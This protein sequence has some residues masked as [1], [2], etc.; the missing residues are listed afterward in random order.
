MITFTGAGCSG[1]LLTAGFDAGSVVGFC[2]RFAAPICVILDRKSKVPPL[3]TTPL[4]SGIRTPPTPVSLMTRRTGTLRCRELEEFGKMVEA[5][6][7][8]DFS[9]F[10]SSSSPPGTS[11]AKLTAFIFFA[12][13]A[14]TALSLG[15][16]ASIAFVE[17][18]SVC[19]SASTTCLISGASDSTDTAGASKAASGVTGATGAAG[20]TGAAGA[21]ATFSATFS[22]SRASLSCFAFHSSARKSFS[23]TR[24]H[25]RAH[26]NIH[27]GVTTN[28][29]GVALACTCFWVPRRPGWM[30][31]CVIGKSFITM[32]GHAPRSTAKRHK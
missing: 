2:S 22:D 16:A 10:V 8:A 14:G 18:A 27:S 21:S 24:D 9:P 3:A 28:T 30:T 4:C 25:V 6:P 15:F 13:D 32:L 19:S 31:K 26:L 29:F 5:A 7:I 1:L 11:A 12:T 20:T 17:A 23:E